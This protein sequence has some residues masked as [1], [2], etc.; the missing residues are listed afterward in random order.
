MPH[1]PHHDEH[2][3]RNLEAIEAPLD[4]AN[5]SLADALRSSFRILKG[6]MCVLVVLYLFSN[7]RCIDQHEQALVLTFGRLQEE[8][9]DPGLMWAWPFPVDEVVT[10]PAMESNEI[11]VRTHTFR[12]RKNEQGKSLDH[13]VRN[14]MQGLNPV[15]DGALLTADRGLVHIEWL[16]QYKIDAVDQYV[17]KYRGAGEIASHGIGAADELIT[18]IVETV[19][20]HVAS[21]M[22]ADDLVRKDTDRATSEVKHRINELLDTLETGISVHGVEMSE[23]TV[24]I[25]VRRAFVNAQMA[26]ESRTARIQDARREESRLLSDTAGAAYTQ[27]LALLDR[28][29]AVGDDADERRAIEEALDYELTNRVEGHAG[30]MIRNAGAYYAVTVGEMESDIRLYRSYLPEYQRNPSLLIARLWEETKQAIF[31][32]P[33]VRK[34]YRPTALG[35]VRIKIGRD[36]EQ[37]R[38]DEE[39]RM[40]KKAFDPASLS[41]KRLVP[42][43]RGAD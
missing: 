8:V 24:P 18:K 36:A 11:L 35:E 12:R 6:I 28:L 1:D 26:Q 14:D 30:E 17:R 41:D 7:V 22:N 23:Y 25:Q 9:R 27:V 13:L 39:E 34:I 19:A 31:D 40:R 29:D 5:Q 43:G 4:A 37:V 38:K 42:I 2:A 32:R 10:L 33:G 15:Y 3:H 20:I 16:V 21:E